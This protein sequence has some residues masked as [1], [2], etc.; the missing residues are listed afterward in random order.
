MDLG[1]KVAVRL[2]YFENQI[3]NLICRGEINISVKNDSNVS[4]QCN[5]IIHPVSQLQVEVN[6]RTREH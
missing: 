4:I 3:L 2:K 1:F 5:G 6:G